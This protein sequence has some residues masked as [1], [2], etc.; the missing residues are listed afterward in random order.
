MSLKILAHE[1]RRQ[2]LELGQYKIN[3]VFAN[4]S[5]LVM[6]TG[7]L[8][9]FSSTADVF[10]TFANL[11]CWY[12]ATHG[13]THPSFFLEDEIQDRTIVSVVSSDQGVLFVLVQRMLIQMVLDLVKALPL[14]AFIAIFMNIQ[15]PATMPALFVI[16]MLVIIGIY[17]LGTLISSFTLVS[18]KTSNIAALL[19]YFIFF[20]A[21]VLETPSI[22]PLFAEAFPF[23]WFKHYIA[24]GNYIYL[25]IILFQSL[26]YWV[27]GSVVFRCI[28]NRSLKRGSMFYV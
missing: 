22:F 9:L 27:L 6:I 21:G 7:Y 25:L 16:V 18:H 8:G 19:S 26:M 20:F 13:I 3:L 28:L 11:F 2:F 23:I 24:T 4:L 12:M 5:L 15:I 14:F 1:F 17:G 10:T